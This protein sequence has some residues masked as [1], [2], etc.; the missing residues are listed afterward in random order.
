[1]WWVTKEAE[2]SLKTRVETSHSN[3]HMC[4]QTI[5]IS[6]F[7]YKQPDLYGVASENKFS[8]ISRLDLNLPDSRV[9]STY[10]WKILRDMNMILK[11]NTCVT[12]MDGL[13]LLGVLGQF[14]FYPSNLFF[15][16]YFKYIFLLNFLT[17]IFCDVKRPI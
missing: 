3:Y 8:E 16:Q 13:T 2:S 9:D 5:W 14:I 11:Y 12:N 7:S 17:V 1:M 15:L 4:G 10:V 6:N